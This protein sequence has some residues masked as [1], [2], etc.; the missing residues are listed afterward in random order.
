M[1]PSS[2]AAVRTL[3]SF[4]R[5]TRRERCSPSP[6]NLAF[7]TVH[8]EPRLLVADIGRWHIAALPVEEPGLLLNYPQAEGLGWEEHDDPS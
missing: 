5:T 7:G 3:P 6:T 1:R 4:T 2:S 8:R